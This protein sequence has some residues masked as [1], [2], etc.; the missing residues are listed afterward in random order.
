[1]SGG[2]HVSK[3]IAAPAGAV[4][5]LLSDASGYATWNDA[6]V[7]LDGTIE[8][9][10]VIELVSILD[11]K[12]T[13]RLRV[14]EFDPPKRMV[15]TDSMPLGL[16]T[17]TRTYE[18]DDLGSGACRFSMTEGFAG[19]LAP[20]ITRFIPDMT[21]SFEVFAESLRRAAEGT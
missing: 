17:G 7:S 14:S 19:P 5:Q 13:F 2:Y 3:E 10:S 6:V 15:W 16:F 8:Q 21:E 18:I 1:M 20:L 4:W 9:G 12:R 11:P